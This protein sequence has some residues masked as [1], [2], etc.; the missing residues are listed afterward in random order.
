MHIETSQLI[1]SANIWIAI[2]T[3]GNVLLNGFKLLNLLFNPFQIKFLN[4]VPHE[5]D[6]G[7]CKKNPLFHQTLLSFL[8]MLS[9]FSDFVRLSFE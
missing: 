7:S 4:C 1:L 8:F 6:F 3:K 2:L 9:E 5:S